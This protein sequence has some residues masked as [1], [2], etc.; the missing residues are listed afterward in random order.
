[1]RAL[2]LLCLCLSWSLVSS[3]QGFSSSHKEREL[4]DIIS[5]TKRPDGQFDVIC[6]DGSSEIKSA[7]DVQFGEICAFKTESVRW[8]LTSGGVSGSS[9]MCDFVTE[10]VEKSGSVISFNASFAAPCAVTL[11][12]SSSCG[13]QSC[14]VEI[15]GEE[16]LLFFDS[17][18]EMTI[19]RLNDGLIGKY[20]AY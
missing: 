8:S 10:K 11:N 16:F 9:R 5:I 19:T 17:E 2:L 4:N 6:K 20:E 7:D 12:T 18:F 14:N 3:A 1:M 15:A 13:P